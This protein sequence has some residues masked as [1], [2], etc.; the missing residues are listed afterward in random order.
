MD[1]EGRQSF[2]SFLAMKERKG[3]ESLRERPDQ[4]RECM[5]EGWQIYK[6]EK[7]QS[8]REGKA[9][10]SNRGRLKYRELKF[11][12][13]SCFFLFLLVVFFFCC[14]FFFEKG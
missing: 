11:R 1:G 14:L 8:R 7:N 2:N 9:R 10:Y 3:G 6:L 5:S 12:D 13:N 4:S